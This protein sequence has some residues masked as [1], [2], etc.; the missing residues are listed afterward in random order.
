MSKWRWVVES[1]ERAISG[2]YTNWVKFSWILD[3]NHSHFEQRTHSQLI[4]IRTWQYILILS[5]TLTALN[6][7]NNRDWSAAMSAQKIHLQVRI[8]LVEYLNLDICR[9]KRNMLKYVELCLNILKWFMYQY[10]RHHSL[11]FSRVLDGAEGS[12]AFSLAE[13]RHQGLPSWSILA[14]QNWLRKVQSKRRFLKHCLSNEKSVAQ[15]YSEK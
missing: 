5:H 8:G 3:R 10:H 15:T 7:K 14:C 12:C 2:Y 11:S 13:G 4:H 1:S 6:L 9:K